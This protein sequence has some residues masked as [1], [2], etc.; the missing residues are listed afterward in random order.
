MMMTQDRLKGIT[1][2]VASVEQGS[3]TAA[4]AV[5]HLTSSA[6][7]KS[8]ARLEARLGSR[9]FERTTRRLAL[10]DAGQAFYETC[11]RVLSELAEAESVL[12]AQRAIP[13]GRLRI[14]VPNTFGRMQVMPLINEF[15][16]QNPEMQIALSFSDRFVD[17]FEEGVDIAIRIGGST[18]FPPSLGYRFLGNERL[19]FCASPDYLAQHGVPDSLQALTERRA[20]VYDRVDGSTSPWHIRSPDGRT[21]TRTLPYRMA[22][23]DGEAQVGAVVAGLGVAQMATWLMEKELASGALVPILPELAVEGLPLFIVWPRRKQLLP[24]VDALL[25]TLDRLKISQ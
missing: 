12:A 3:F 19:I 6:I 22:L 15:C 9:L 24:K 18:D 1:P 8:V 7:S 10:T 14:A 4:A 13:V 17:L 16:Q 20:I 5:L 21:I 2:F 11:T 25:A 23:G